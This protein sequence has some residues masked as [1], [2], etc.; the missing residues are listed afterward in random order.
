MS[1]SCIR[2]VGF[3]LLLVHDGLIRHWVVAAGSDVEIWLWGFDMLRQSV[4]PIGRLAI[5]PVTGDQNGQ[6]GGIM[7]RCRPW[8][9]ETEGKLHRGAKGRRI[10]G[11]LGVKS[12]GLRMIRIDSTLGLGWKTNLSSLPSSADGK[13]KPPGRSILNAVRSLRGP[14][15]SSQSFLGLSS[16]ERHLALLGARSPA[17]HHPPSTLHPSPIQHLLPSITLNPQPFSSSYFLY[18]IN[19]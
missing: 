13:M 5:V 18:S 11:V 4:E 2:T 17:I 14:N 3:P 15:Q 9:F 8:T 7:S 16:P 6:I 1:G 19:L 10:P 12:K